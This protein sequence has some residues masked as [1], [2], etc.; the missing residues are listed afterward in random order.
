MADEKV[1]GYATGLLEVAR[2]EGQADRVGDELFRIARSFESA[3]D[4]REAL[5]DP[6]VPTERKLGIVGDILGEKA[7]PVT[8][9]LV[10][11]VVEMGQARHLP[12]IADSLAER[13][14]AQRDRE[15]AEVRSAVEL[16]DETLQRLEQALNSA[17]GKRVEIKAVVDPSV[18][19]GVVARVGDVVIDGSVQRRFRSLRQS[20][21]NRE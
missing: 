5:V 19:G 9:S 2:A 20:L 15:V 18:I 10:K 17:T 11:F 21:E 6:Q 12:D 16:D 13:L 14:A 8:V 1:H 3:P 4:L 7:S